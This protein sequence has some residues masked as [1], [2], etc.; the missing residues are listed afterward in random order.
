MSSQVRALLAV[1]LATV[2]LF[3]AQ[4]LLP[5]PKESKESS[6]PSKQEAV[7][8]ATKSPT[9]PASKAPGPLERP[10]VRE[11]V[12]RAPEREAIVETDVVRAVLTSR[13]GAL[14]SWRLKSYRAADGQGVDLV[15]LQQGELPGPLLVS[16]GNPEE[17]A[18]LD[19]DIDKAEVSLRSPSETGSI[20]FSSRGS[21]PLQLSKR[22]TFKGN[23]YRVEVEFSWKNTGKKP[24]TIAP[25]IAWGPGFYSGVDGERAQVVSA[26][27]WVDGR[28][29]TDDLGSLKGAVTHSGQVS[30]TALQNLYFAAALL[31]EGK[32]STATI[33]KGPEEQ[34]VI[35]LVTPTQSLEPGGGLTQRVAVYSGPKDLDHLN[36]AGSD[37][38]KI[39][40]LGWFDALAR[41]ALHLL[42]F[43]NR[44]SGNYGVAIILVSVLQKIV[45]HPLTAKSLRSMQAMKALQPKIAAISERNKNNPQKKQQEVMGLYKKHGVNPLGGCLPMLIQLPIFVALYNALSSSVEMW[46]APFLWI[47]DLS[48]PDALFA[49]DVWGL[50]D[51]PFNLLALLMG[52]SMFFQQ[53]MSPPSS[54]DPQQAKLMLWMMPTMFTFMFWTFP[55]GLVLYWLVSNILQMGQQQWLQKRGKLA[56]S[57][58]E[59]T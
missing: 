38:S 51:Y 34:P 23:S 7:G 40:D 36:A 1:A 27:S 48:Q 25:E 26:T 39:V 35:A 46:R 4:F 2:I 53:K 52:A 19:F 32:G 12:P 47:K 6:E 56:L 45:L 42:R 22:L 43:L 31:P 54:S 41:P 14:K 37:L 24:I 17:P 59:A 8:T 13:G 33:R 10:Q 29:V 28:R 57:G 5:G 55:S 20:T 49:F 11:V 58:P 16:S 9:S 21:G 44:I 3:G 30:W 18:P 50:K 15:A